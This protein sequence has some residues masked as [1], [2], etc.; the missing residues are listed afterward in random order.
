MI[1]DPDNFLT[2]SD[3]QLVEIFLQ[4]E[5]RWTRRKIINEFFKRYCLE[6]DKAIRFGLKYER[7]PYESN[8]EYYD[9]VFTKF[10]ERIFDIKLFEKKLS[11]F[12][13][14][15]V[16]RNFFLII[17]KNEFRDWLK[18]K[19]PEARLT[20]REILREMVQ[21]GNQTENVDTFRGETVHE[22]RADISLIEN[23]KGDS[24][25]VLIERLPEPYRVLIRLRFI[26]YLD[27]AP[28][29]I[30]CIANDRKDPS[31]KIVREIET[32]K[33]SMREPTGMIEM[34]KHELL[35]T[36]FNL[37]IANLE[38][39][40]F[41]LTKKINALGYPNLEEVEEK[42]D[43][44]SLKDISMMKRGGAKGILE[45]SKINSSYLEGEIIQ[46]LETLKRLQLVSNRRDRILQEKRGRKDYARPENFQI[47]KILGIKEGTVGSRKNRAKEIL[48]RN[49]KEIGI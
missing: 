28:E 6:F 14:N 19:D 21:A 26:A 33:E 37:R 32:L 7:I 24:I 11:K 49:L 29:D 42:I 10:Y 13:L 3:E 43:G 31:I 23:A 41:Y 39:K 48:L 8:T 35:L 2:L 46:Y 47:A 9:K 17:L 16:F 4:A 44:Y 36:S 20:N 27:M 30:E 5:D 40:A 45:N 25:L 38:R 1:E 12:D 15:G 22:E 34:E 18:K